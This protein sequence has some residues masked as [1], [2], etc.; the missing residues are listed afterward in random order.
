[1]AKDE[2]DLTV[3]ERALTRMSNESESAK[4][5][6]PAE[7]ERQQDPGPAG[8]SAGQETS[9]NDQDDEVDGEPVID[10]MELAG[11]VDAMNVA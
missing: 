2:R 3:L 5:A 1:M 6:G 8:P 7:P 9:N 4:D 10:G 11:E